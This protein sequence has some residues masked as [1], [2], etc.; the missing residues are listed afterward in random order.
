MPLLLLIHKLDSVF[1]GFPQPL[2]ALG[3]PKKESQ[4]T[5]YKKEV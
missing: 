3:S 2:P 1:L 5:P 4:K